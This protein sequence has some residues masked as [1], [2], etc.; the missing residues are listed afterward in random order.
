MFSDGL[1]AGTVTH[2]PLWARQIAHLHAALSQVRA[3]GIELF[4]VGIESDAV[5]TYYAPDF[6]VVNSA[7]DL[8]RETVRALDRMLR[9]GL[10][11]QG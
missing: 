10:G 11:R 3:S 4:G 7:A 5:Q 8:P 1:P 6:V 9:G 2:A